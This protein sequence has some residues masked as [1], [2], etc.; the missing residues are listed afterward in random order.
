[1]ARKDRGA[2]RPSHPAHGDTLHGSMIHG[3]FLGIENNERIFH[4][5]SLPMQ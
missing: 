3:E 1:M 5:A 2:T 4:R